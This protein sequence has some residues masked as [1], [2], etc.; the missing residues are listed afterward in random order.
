M[1]Y[2]AFILCYHIPRTA[3][4][5][6][7]TTMRRCAHGH[8]MCK[9]PHPWQRR[10]GMRDTRACVHRE[11]AWNM[12]DC[13]HAIPRAPQYHHR[14]RVVLG[15]GTLVPGWFNRFEGK[16]V[17]HSPGCGLCAFPCSALCLSPLR[18]SASLPLSAPARCSHTSTENACGGCASLPSS[19]R[20]PKPWLAWRAKA[21]NAAA[22]SAGQSRSIGL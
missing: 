13:T 3:F 17:V 4:T 22:W 9:A 6:A 16:W 21:V 5:F 10:V 11:M 20:P 18:L 15:K 12:D 2:L 8:N 1:A 14:V 7:W 19:T